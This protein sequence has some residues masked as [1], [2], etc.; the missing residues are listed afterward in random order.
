M[1]TNVGNKERIA[2]V[3]AGLTILKSAKSKKMKALGLMPLVSG[4]TGHCPAY[5]KLGINTASGTNH[6]AAKKSD[7]PDN[8]DTTDSKEQAE[9]V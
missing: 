9:T 2:R 7:K 6:K 5:Q 4:A 3:L 1:L 8:A